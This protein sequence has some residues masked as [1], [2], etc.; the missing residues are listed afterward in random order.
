MTDSSNSKTDIPMV[1]DNE[2]IDARWTK[3]QCVAELKRVF[4]L[5]PSKFMTRNYFRNYSRI[6]EV[7]WN[8]HFGTFTEFKRSGGV[9]LTRHAHR[10]ELDVAKHASVDTM[11]NFNSQKGSYEDKYLL[12]S[13][14]RFQTLIHI[15]DIHDKECDPFVY[16]VFMSALERIKPNKVIIGG[17]LF[18][19][20]E[21]GKYSV[22]PREW[23]VIGRIKWVH[24]FLADIRKNA[25]DAEITLV[26]GNHEYRLMRHLSEATPAMRAVLSDLHGFTV[27]K[28]LGLD[29]F[30]VNYVSRSDLA[31]FT[32]GDVTKEITKNYHISYNCYL[33]HHFP[34][35]MK[36]GMPGAHGH[37]HRHTATQLYNPTFGSYEW[38]QL[39]CGHRRQASYCAGEQWGNGFNIA[40]VDTH[41]KHVL[42]EYVQIRNFAVLGGRYYQRLP[43][44][45]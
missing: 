3:N 25:P 31:S 40:H 45:I 32:K 11:R 42:H 29:E 38:H 19:L 20:P 24:N 27:S 13:S 9:L 37:H 21:F 30:Q 33:T 28:L 22:D 6:K 1:E 12:P 44:E 43:T 14:Y 5:D 16:R 39:G 34:E 36:L 15:T 41:N 35:G 26:E 7:V 4:D 8:R 23:D 18:D 2:K 10:M 17:D